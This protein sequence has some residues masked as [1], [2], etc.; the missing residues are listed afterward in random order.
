M[1]AATQA[2]YWVH[3]LQV[4]YSDWN[5]SRYFWVD[6]NPKKRGNNID[7]KARH[8]FVHID[9]GVETFI[10]QRSKWQVCVCVIHSKVS[11]IL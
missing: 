6:Y 9:I 1:H 7:T 10:R 11:R 3:C 5:G 8:Y 2:K 4:L